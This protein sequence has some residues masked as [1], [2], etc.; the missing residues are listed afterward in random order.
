MTLLQSSPVSKYVRF[1]ISTCGEKSV[2]ITAP[3]KD[4]KIFIDITSSKDRSEYRVEVSTVHGSVMGDTWFGGCSWSH[5]EKYF[6]Y[7]AQP[8]LVKQTPA[9]TVTG[10]EY[11]E[12]WGEKFTNISDCVLCIINTEVTKE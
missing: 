3:D 8:L 6:V 10:F 2:G 11:K 7:T 4:K 12:D 1:D 9:S 5:D